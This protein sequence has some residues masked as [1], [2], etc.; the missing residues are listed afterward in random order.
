MQSS[1]PAGTLIPSQLRLV[2]SCGIALVL[3]LLSVASALACTPP[4]GGLPIIPIAQRVQAADVVLEGTVTQMSATNFQDDTATISVLRYFKGSGPITVTITGFGLGALCRSFVQAGDRLSHLIA[5]AD[6][7]ALACLQHRAP[8]DLVNVLRVGN[9]A[10]NY[11][12]LR[13]VGAA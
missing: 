13:L 3:C 10:K 4:P 12:G 1:V 6:P 8:D 2:L 9:V 11:L 7:V 5:E